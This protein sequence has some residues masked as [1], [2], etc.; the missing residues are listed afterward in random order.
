MPEKKI[1]QIIDINCLYDLTKMPH[2][3]ALVF[4]AVKS[5]KSQVNDKKRTAKE[6]M[7]LNAAD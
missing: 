2:V 5:S 7:R 3:T 6:R 4:K 1:D